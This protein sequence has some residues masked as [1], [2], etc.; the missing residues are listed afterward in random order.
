MKSIVEVCRNFTS[1]L[2]SIHGRFMITKRHFEFI[3][4]RTYILHTAFCAG[5]QIDNIFGF[6][7]KML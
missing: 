2:I 5:D 7:M 3:A 1:V 4:S 6:A